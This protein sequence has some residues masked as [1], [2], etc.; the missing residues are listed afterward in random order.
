MIGAF[1][2][3]I[4]KALEAMPP[5]GYLL[6]F[7]LACMWGIVGKKWWVPALSVLLFLWGSL[8]YDLLMERG[9][10]NLWPFEVLLYFVYAVLMAVDGL[11]GLF[12]RWYFRP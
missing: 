1:P 2:E 8:A 5:A 4:L 11:I 6:F 3:R 9:S 10:H 12:L 7:I